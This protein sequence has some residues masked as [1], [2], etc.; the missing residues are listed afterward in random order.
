MVSRGKDPAYGGWIVHGGNLGPIADA[1]AEHC[2]YDHTPEQKQYI[3]D[4]MAGASP[5]APK[6]P[7]REAAAWEQGRQKVLAWHAI[8]TNEKLWWNQ[9]QTDQVTI[10][11]RVY[12]EAYKGT[13]VSYL[14]SARSKGLTGY[15]FRAPGEWFAEL[16]AGYHCEK[17]KKG[18][19]A[20]Q[21]RSS[22]SL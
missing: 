6:A 3:L 17:L 8:V 2:Q 19:P 14:A 1:V 16:Y 20:R 9:A 12:Q 10:K 13:W 21:W 4:L 7:P 18:H 15:Q 11:G 5:I 22:L